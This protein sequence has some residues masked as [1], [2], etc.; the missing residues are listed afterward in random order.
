M[1]FGTRDRDVGLQRVSR[2][3]RWLVAGTVGLV[4]VLSAVVAQ[5][6][7]GNSGTSAATT[8]SP[9]GATASPSAPAPTPTSP[10]TTQD[11]GLSGGSSGS[12]S[13]SSDPNLT[14]SPPPVSTR[15]QSVASS[16]GS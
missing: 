3:T 10:T 16:G 4:G 1:R 9:S 11:P 14:P 5:A 13:S 7:P 8:G 15:H 12:S 6:L 2:L